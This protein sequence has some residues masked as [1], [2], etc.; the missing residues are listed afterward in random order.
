MEKITLDFNNEFKGE[1]VSDNAKLLI[2]NQEGGLRPYNL[3]FSALASCFYATFLSI[4]QKKRLNF[5]GAR[6][7][8]DGRK[9]Q[10]V[11]TTL[12]YVTLKLIIQDAK[13]KKEGF[14]RS[15]ELAGEY[16]SIYQTI[17]K[18]AQMNLEVE[19]ID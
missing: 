1:L 17:S 18:V 11:P 9:R 10:E 7:E 16:C 4:V 8:V 3:L 2:G 14:I 6:I 15:A 13:E 12:E 19:F 5:S